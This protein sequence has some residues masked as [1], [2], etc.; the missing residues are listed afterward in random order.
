[1]A[2]S[3][4]EWILDPLGAPENSEKQIPR[5][6]PRCDKSKETY[7]HDRRSCPSLQFV[8]GGVFSSL[9]EWFHPADT[10]A[11]EFIRWAPS[12]RKH[13]QL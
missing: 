8:R 13:P 3:G 7:R 2:A 11:G 10:D 1:M 9:L 6:K 4:S 12:A 5:V